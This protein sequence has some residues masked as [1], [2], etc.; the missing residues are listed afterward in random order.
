M[1]ML[2]YCS[3]SYPSDK[4]FKGKEIL[5]YSYYYLNLGAILYYT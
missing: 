1:R 4:H 5:L 3:L 2:N